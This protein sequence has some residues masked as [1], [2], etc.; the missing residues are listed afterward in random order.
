M[1][2][3]KQFLMNNFGDNII[4][5]LVSHLFFEYKACF[6]SH[7]RKPLLKFIEMAET[8]SVFRDVFPSSHFCHVCIENTVYVVGEIFD[9]NCDVS[10]ICMGS[11]EVC[12]SYDAE[13]YDLKFYDS[14]TGECIDMSRV[15]TFYI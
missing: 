6:I 9:K 15:L 7:I 13:T 3:R 10:C 8:T 14:M 5:E 2:L 1:N 12:R 11:S 4:D